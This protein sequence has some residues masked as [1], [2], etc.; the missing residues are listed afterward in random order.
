MSK[1]ADPNRLYFGNVS[2]E[3][4]KEEME[5]F[6]AQC[7][8]VTDMYLVKDKFTGRFQGFGF[9]TFSDSEGKDAA[10]ALNGTDYEGRPLKVNSE[11]R[12]NDKTKN[13][14]RL[15]IRNI[16]T[17]KTEDEVKEAFAEYGTVEEFFFVRDKVTKA[18]KGFGFLDFATGDEATAALA[19]D[20]QDPFGNGQALSVKIAHQKKPVQRG[21]GP[22]FGGRGGYGGYGQQYSPY[23]PPPG[24]YGGFPQPA[25]WQ[26]GG[27][28]GYGGRGGGRGR[29]RGGYGGYGRGRGGYGMQQPAY[30]APPQW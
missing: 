29:G 3:K 5:K 22:A 14:Q 24:P 12:A 11:S 25:P 7:G 1:H 17:D 4:T 30:G 21:Y 23:G 8:T 2:F 9:V 18:P 20:G 26:Q 16:P 27:Y 19:M 6:F 10:L 28:G 13:K 15:F